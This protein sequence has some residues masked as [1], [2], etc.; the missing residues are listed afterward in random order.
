MAGRLIAGMAAPDFTG[1]TLTKKRVRLSDHLGWPVWLILYRYS[2]CPM[3]QVHFAELL[4]RAKKIEAAGMRVIAVFETAKQ[5]LPPPV[6]ELRFPR[7]SLMVDSEESIYE[8]YGSE[9]KLSAVIRPSVA[10]SLARALFKGFR[11]GLVDGKVGRIPAHFLIDEDGVINTVHYGSTIADHIPWNTADSS[12]RTIAGTP[13]TI[14]LCS[15][16]P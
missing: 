1:T 3:C 12:I 2:G 4:K 8:S 14:S 16:S 9:A 7:Y 11:Q 5:K 6:L 13:Y 10:F 15:V